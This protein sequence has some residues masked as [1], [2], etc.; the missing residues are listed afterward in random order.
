MPSD[1]TPPDFK[2]FARWVAS[3]TSASQSSGESW[4]ALLAASRAARD[5]VLRTTQL[6]AVGFAALAAER[7]NIEL[8][9]VLAAATEDKTSLPPELST[10]K[11]FRAALSRD[12]NMGVAQ[13]PSDVARSSIAVLVQA[14]LDRIAWVQDKTAFLWKGAE[15]FELGQFD[16]DGRAYGS[17]PVGVDVTLA[18]FTGANIR[19]EEFGPAVAS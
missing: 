17:L 13:P 2:A 8:L 4:D 18:D 11:G 9:Q 14:P 5:E 7:Q 10:A 15:R 6:P 3:R 19:L 12:T 16:A 1:S